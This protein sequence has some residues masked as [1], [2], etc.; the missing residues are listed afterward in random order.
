[1]ADYQ[2]PISPEVMNF[3]IQLAVAE[4]SAIEFIPAALRRNPAKA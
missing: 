1:L 4:A 2:N 3:Q